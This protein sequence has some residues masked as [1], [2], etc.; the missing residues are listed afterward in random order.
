MN[1]HASTTLLPAAGG[2]YALARVDPHGFVFASGQIGVDPATAQ[3]AS[4]GIAGETA[5]AIDNLA[6]VLASVGCGLDDILKVSVFLADIG[7]FAGMNAVYATRFGQPFPARTTVQATIA[8]GA[9]VEIDAIA[10]R[11][12]G[13][14]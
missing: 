9:L 2:P 11:P 13:A 4:G 12:T 1:K 6:A 7:D 3:L 10:V 8:R 14:E 5:Q